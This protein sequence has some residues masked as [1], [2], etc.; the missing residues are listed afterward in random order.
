MYCSMMLIMLMKKK[1]IVSLD[2]F[3]F[4]VHLGRVYLNFLKKPWQ[5]YRQG[6]FLVSKSCRN[7]VNGL[8]WRGGRHCYHA[9]ILR[10]PGARRPWI[11]QGG[12]SSAPL[13]IQRGPRLPVTTSMV[14]SLYKSSPCIPWSLSERLVCWSQLHIAQVDLAE[15]VH[16]MDYRWLPHKNQL[17]YSFCHLL[18]DLRM[19][20]CSI[21]VPPAALKSLKCPLPAAEDTCAPWVQRWKRVEKP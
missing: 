8:N 7:I 18:V 13:E 15:I 10:P 9:G 1:H 19:T 6:P 21:S 5:L 20:S 17:L 12:R 2:E 14:H 4:Q 3:L 16:P 11:L